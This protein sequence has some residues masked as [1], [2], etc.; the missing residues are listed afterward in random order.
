MDK[1]TYSALGRLLDEL[2]ESHFDDEDPI[3]ADIDKVRDWMDELPK[4]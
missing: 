2:E 4:T 1:D 3:V